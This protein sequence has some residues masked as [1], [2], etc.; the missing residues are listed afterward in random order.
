MA[1]IPWP[2]GRGAGAGAATGCNRRDLRHERF[3]ARPCG[4]PGKAPIARERGVAAAFAILYL[5]RST[6]PQGRGMVDSRWRSDAHIQHT[7]LCR[8]TS[9]ARVGFVPGCRRHPMRE[10]SSVPILTA[11]I[12]SR[13]KDGEIHLPRP[14]SKPAES[15]RTCLIMSEKGPTQGEGFVVDRCSGWRGPTCLLARAFSAEVG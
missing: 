15:S 12:A 4:R 9:T 14:L 10:S 3:S 13:T 2:L 7:V 11:C 1:G 8:I 5:T 6:L